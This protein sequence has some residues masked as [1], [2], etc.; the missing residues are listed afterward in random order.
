V[1]GGAKPDDRKPEREETDASLGAEREKTDAT[2][3]GHDA[4]PEA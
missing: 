2:F 3:A 1:N 4:G